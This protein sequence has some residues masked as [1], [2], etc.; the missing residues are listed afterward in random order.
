MFRRARKRKLQAELRKNAAIYGDMAAIAGRM[1]PEPK[2]VSW[3]TY[4]LVLRYFNV[5]MADKIDKL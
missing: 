5:S 3:R 1:C 4:C 2:A